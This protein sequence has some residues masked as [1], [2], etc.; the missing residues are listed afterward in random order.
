MIDVTHQISA[1]RRM[2]GSRTL[3]AGEARV[4]TISQAYDTDADDLWDACTDIERIPRWFLPIR[5]DLTVGG[6][7]QL[8][9]N[10]HGTILT[11]DPPRAFS[12]TWEY[13]DAVS[14]IEVRIAD[15][16]TGRSRFE[17]NHICHIDDH[18]E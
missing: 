15:E 11:C 18:W 3:D 13:G 12:A 1:V 10:A 9:G 8:E 17:L 5:G 6:H 4:V 16:G 7:Y 14:W 2:V